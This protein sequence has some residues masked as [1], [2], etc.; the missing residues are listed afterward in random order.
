MA[1]LRNLLHPERPLLRRS[2]GLVS[3]SAIG[4]AML[5]VGTLVAARYFAPSAFGVLGVFVTIA[6]VFGIFATGR[7]EAAIPIPRRDGRARDL[8]EVACALVPAVAALSYLFMGTIGV[9]IL[10][11][12]DADAL[13]RHL[14]LFPAATIALGLRALL[15]G[16]CTRKGFIKTLAVGRALNGTSSGIAFVVGAVAGAETIWLVGAWLTGQ[17]VEMLVVA[18]TV[19][20]DVAREPRS[21][22]SRRRRRAL[23]RFRRFPR[24]LLWSHILEE[25]GPHLPITLISGFFGAELA[26][27]YNM[28]QRVVARPAAVIGSSVHVMVASEASKR[29]RSGVDLIPLLDISLKRLAKVAVLLFVPLAVLGPVVLP[30]VL[31]PQWE[32]TGILLLAIL[33]GAAVD[34]VA[35]PLIPVLILVE[36]VFTQLALSVARLAIV[37]LAISASALVGFGPATMLLAL[38]LAIVAIDVISVL[39]YRRALQSIAPVA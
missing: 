10:A 33:P 21:L 5:L 26:G 31:G 2:A 8:L 14:W 36:R 39:I 17:A 18:A 16:W 20:R 34:F 9:S 37:V 29:L 19:L 3:G 35:I 12:A 7:L 11:W 32:D 30:V 38:S 13:S 27:V 22:G 15:I 1:S 24:V 23:R 6:V 28:I 4:Q 25:L